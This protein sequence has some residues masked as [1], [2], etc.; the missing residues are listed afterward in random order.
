[1]PSTDGIIQSQSFRTGESKE[2]QWFDSKRLGIILRGMRKKDDFKTL[3]RIF[4]IDQL[5]DFKVPENTTFSNGLLSEMKQIQDRYFVNK[6]E[7]KNDDDSSSNMMEDDSR[8]EQSLLQRNNRIQDAKTWIFMFMA[9]KR[10]NILQHGVCNK[11]YDDGEIQDCH[12]SVADH[13]KWNI[14]NL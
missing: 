4:D 2:T 7:S 8:N 1:M 12:H 13:F 9:E 5:S 6:S 11:I 14:F 3:M 10:T